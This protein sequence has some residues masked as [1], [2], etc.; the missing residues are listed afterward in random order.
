V[1][2]YY[3]DDGEERHI[4]CGGQVLNF[5]EGSIC[6]KCKKDGDLVGTC[7][8]CATGKH[9]KCKK[10]SKGGCPANC[11]HRGTKHTLTHPVYAPGAPVNPPVP[12]F[13]SAADHQTEPIHIPAGVSVGAGLAERAAERLELLPDTT[14]TITGHFHKAPDM[15]W[16]SIPKNV[17]PELVKAYVMRVET[18][19]TEERCKCPWQEVDTPKGKRKVKLADHPDCS[20]HTKEGFINGF[21]AFVFDEEKGTHITLTLT[22]EDEED[23]SY[24]G[25]NDGYQA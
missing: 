12:L 14:G 6:S 17:L 18:D 20:V 5:K 4:G 1:D 7:I 13:I 25:L 10:R 16:V 2:S 11:Q 3:D 8:F 21:F 9:G 23:E 24:P 22:N 15:E 19:P